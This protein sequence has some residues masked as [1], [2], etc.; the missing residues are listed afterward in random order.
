M[1]ICTCY[2]SYLQIIITAAPR[3]APTVIDATAINSTLLNI[4]WTMPDSNYNHIVT[5]TNL[6]TGMVVSI[7]VTKDTSS[8]LVK[9]F[10]GVDNYNVT[11]ATNNSC[12]MKFSDPITVEGKNYIT[13]KYIQLYDYNR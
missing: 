9:G 6:R 3:A 2:Y 4:T 12:G 5:W 7:A 13:D 1:Y 10:N 11:V 8:Y